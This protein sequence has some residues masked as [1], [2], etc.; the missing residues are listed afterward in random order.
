MVRKT[1]PQCRRHRGTSSVIYNKQL[2]P[3]EGEAGRGEACRRVAGEAGALPGPPRDRTGPRGEA[4]GP[5]GKVGGGSRH[6]APQRES[7]DGKDPG[8]G[9]ESIGGAGARRSRGTA[10]AHWSVTE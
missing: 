4:A 9:R 10:E 3:Q 8:P 6:G 5:A 1:D 7:K 2:K